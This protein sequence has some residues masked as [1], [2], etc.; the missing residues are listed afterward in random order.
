MKSFSAIAIASL[1]L[2]NTVH[3]H[4]IFQYLTANGAK[5]AI[6]QNVRKNTNN[7]SPVTDLASNDLRCNVGGGTSGGTT[8]VS[9]AA[10]SSVTFTADIAVYHQG[11]VSFYLSKVADAASADGSTTWAKIKQI[12]PTFP[13]GTWNMAQSYSVSI[14]SCVAPG[15]YL[16]RIEQLAIHNPGSP[17]Q[18]YISCAQIKVTGGGSKSF[19]GVRIPGHVKSSDPGYTANIYNNFNSYTVPGPAVSTC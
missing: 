1:A 19:A 5:G 13:G 14:P 17:P 3:G 12:G 4:Y 2:V 8:T 6:Y 16:L 11:P 10:G 15:D 18:F 7:N 9:V